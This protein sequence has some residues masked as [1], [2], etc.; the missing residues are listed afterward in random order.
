M[1]YFL[2]KGLSVY[3]V[4]IWTFSEIF[5]TLQMFLLSKFLLTQAWHMRQNEN[6]NDY[7]GRCRGLTNAILTSI[8]EAPGGG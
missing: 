1:Y 5:E 2:P 6:E 3:S 8:S 4:M 7:R